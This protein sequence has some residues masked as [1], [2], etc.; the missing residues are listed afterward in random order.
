MSA[1][2]GLGGLEAAPLPV[3]ARCGSR[4]PPSGQLGP[5]SADPQREEIVGGVPERR[6]AETQA[7]T[8]SSGTPSI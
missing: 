4:A 8:G 2:T 7:K 5:R 1:G 6:R 3:R